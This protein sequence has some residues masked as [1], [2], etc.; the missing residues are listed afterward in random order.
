VTFFD[1]AFVASAGT[2]YHVWLRL[3][4][5]NDSLSNDSVHVQFSDSITAAGAPLAR[6]GT[7]DSAEFVLQNG[8]TGAQP[9]GWGWTD[10]GWG[11]LGS[12]IYFASTGTHTLRIQQREDGLTVD[13]IVI[14]PD[15]YLIAPP[16]ARRDDTTILSGSSPS[17]ASN[18]PPT[19]TLTSPLAGSTFTAPASITF[20]ASA[21]DPEGRLARVEFWSGTTKIGT[22]TTA[23]YSLPVSA[24]AAGTYAISALAVDADGGQSRSASVSITVNTVATTTKTWTVVFTASPDHET[25]VTSYR[26]DAFASGANPATAA[27]LITANLG[28]PGPDANR[29]IR[30]NETPLIGTLSTGSYLA[31]V[32]AIGPGGQTRSASY[33][34]TR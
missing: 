14:S 19:V 11:A 20:T 10:N 26:F 29:E 16:G 31:T 32:T 33:T 8:P 24:V 7:T 5:V 2:R 6:I 15:A 17:T 13:Q 28:K 23:P 18:Q 25:N 4:A 12:D 34:F 1:T 9:H 21:S 30:V 27:P 22:D 3:K